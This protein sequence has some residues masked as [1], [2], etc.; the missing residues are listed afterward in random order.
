MD[1]SHNISSLNEDLGCP[2]TEDKLL[3]IIYKNMLGRYHTKIGKDE[4]ST[5]EE[6]QERVAKEERNHVLNEICRLEGLGQTVNGVLTIEELQRFIQ[7]IP[8]EIA[9]TP[10]SHNNQDS[11]RS[12]QNSNAKPNPPNN[13]QTKPSE[14]VAAATKPAEA[15]APV[16]ENVPGTM[17]AP[18]SAPTQRG[19]YPNQNA[20]VARAPNA[21]EQRGGYPNGNGPRSNLAYFDRARC[22]HF[23]SN[24][25][26]YQGDITTRK[27][28]NTNFVCFH[29]GT[30]GFFQR[31]CPRCTPESEI[32]AWESMTRDER[33]KY[34]EDLK[35]Q[36]LAVQQPRTT[37]SN[38]THNQGNGL[39][40]DQ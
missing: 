20:P 19:G 24:D 26:N 18:P 10:K 27:G 35:A 25:Q 14:F 1:F 7:G 12:K 13:Q 3:R 17:A 28:Y 22:Y 9:P 40:E 23:G 34:L 39:W 6:L 36:R 31:M 33:A 4:C 11:N 29:C 37:V 30:V 16:K 32:A 38:V 8:V 2:F 21:P 5:L 15:K